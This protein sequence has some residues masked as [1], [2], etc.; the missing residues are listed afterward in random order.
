MLLNDN[1]LLSKLSELGISINTV[2]HVPL[3]TVEEARRLRINIEGAHVK[4]L[5]LKDR[6]CTY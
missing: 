6:K 5:F 1:D 4:N 2:D 3:R